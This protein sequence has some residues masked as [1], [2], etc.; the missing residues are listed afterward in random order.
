[1]LQELMTYRNVR[2]THNRFDPW[3]YFRLLHIITG[4][5]PAKKEDAGR[6][7][8]IH[9]AWLKWGEQQGFLL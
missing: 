6:L 7:V 1:M 5:W 8:K 9:K 3:L 2:D 4:E